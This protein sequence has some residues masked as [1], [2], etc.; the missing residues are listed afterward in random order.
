MSRRA[1]AALFLAFL[2]GACTPPSP[3]ESGD[4]AAPAFVLGC[5]SIEQPECEA[6][7]QAAVA[8]APAARGGP[9]AITVYLYGC[10]ND[11]PCPR[12][13]AAREGKVT[14]ECT[15]G[16]EPIDLSVTGPPDAPR[17]AVVDTAWSGLQQ[18]S[19]ARAEGPGPFDFELGH[20][21]LTWQVDFDGSF[22]VPVG[23]VDGDA[24]GAINAERGKMLLLGPNVAR[25]AGET[26][27]LATLARFPG[28]K[29]VWL[30]A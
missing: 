18:P 21:G 3:S 6:V 11:G 9:F 1:I 13:L 23:Q 24:S 4:H 20:C 2:T 12:T 7:A 14:L 19:S 27:F 15:D 29:H 10:P 8:R 5:L 30:C 25:Y 22:W 16:D 26:G 28:P 17:F